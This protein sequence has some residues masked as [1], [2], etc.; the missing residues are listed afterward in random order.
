MKR[1]LF[2]AVTAFALGEVEGL[3][4]DRILQI[5]IAAAVLICAAVHVVR[6]KKYAV[7]VMIYA[8]CMV[9][10]LVNVAVRRPVDVM[11][12]LGAAEEAQQENVS[13]CVEGYVYGL[14]S[15]EE[16]CNMLL[17]T[18]GDGCK[19]RLIVY[20]VSENIQ[21]GNYISVKGTLCK[22]MPAENPGGFDAQAYLWSRGIDG[23]L[24][25]PV[26]CVLDSS[27]AGS[28]PV[29]Q[30][31]YYKWKDIVYH[32][33]CILTEKLYL[34]TDSSTACMYAGILLG[35]KKGIPA[36]LL[37]L[38]QMAGISHI[39]AIS[40][41]H[42]TLLGMGVFR[43]LRR[44]GMRLSWT[45]ALSFIW[46]LFYGALTGWSFATIRA[47]VMLVIVIGGECLGRGADLLTGAAAALGIML[48]AEPYRL[49]DGGMVLS[50][51]AI[52]GVAFGRYILQRLR[53]MQRMK[54]LKH[55]RLCYML[56]VSVIMSFCLQLVM[57]PVIARL[58]YVIPSYSVF[59]NL[60]VVPLLTPVL[61]SGAVGLFSGCINAGWGHV[62]CMPGQYILRFYTWLCECTVRLPGSS[63]GTGKPELWLIALYYLLLVLLVYFSTEAPQRKLREL[64]Y[65]KR[66][67]WYG[68]KSWRRGMLIMYCCMIGIAGVCLYGLHRYT[69]CEQVTFLDVGQG[70]GILIRTEKGTNLVIDGGSVSRDSLGEYVLAPALQSLAMTRVDYW[71][72]S[73]TDTDH[74]SGLLEILELG[75]LSGVHIENMVVSA[76]A[77]Q[78]EVM[79]ELVQLA[80]G[81]GISVYYMEVGEYVTDGESFL[82]RCLHPDNAFVAEDKNEASLALEYQSDYFR[83]LFTGDM[84][85]DALRYMLADEMNGAGRRYDVVKAP[86]HGSKYSCMEELYDMTDAVVISCGQNNRYG[87]PHEEVIRLLEE[88]NIRIYRTDYDGAIIFRH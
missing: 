33:R 34:I 71:F 74:I 56:L 5:S 25:Q 87:H 52:S 13:V 10:G 31:G 29:L 78:D 38:Y 1:P 14:Q 86:H 80:Y 50:F 19:M 69:L 88:K 20:G 63:I 82:M 67:V 53:L 28:L 32:L 36:R 85:T 59:V 22:P 24:Y 39:L 18:E 84:G 35:D 47:V 51:T 73:H 83:M 9:G 2:W 54:R 68:R 45:T 44:T 37:R 46:I 55:K 43:L 76:Y 57:A 60:L 30:R 41:L 3:Y 70:D 26:C 61:L 72:V 62:I 23:I 65:R 79:C 12:C 8:M 75:E 11:K 7:Y 6:R 81:Q 15:A 4:F 40:G 49:L 58:Y 21:I 48:L 16:G 77:V 66:H 27:V 42:V 64:L 17:Y